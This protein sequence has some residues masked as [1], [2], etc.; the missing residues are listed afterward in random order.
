MALPF[1]AT[2]RDMIESML[3]YTDAAPIESQQRRVRL[4]ILNAYRE[5]PQTHEWRY[6]KKH[7]RIQLDAPYST[8]TVT[9]VASTGNVTLSGGTWPTWARQGHL[10]FTGAITGSSIIYKVAERL[11]ATLIRLEPDFSPA[12]SI[13]IGVAYKI[14]RS[15]YLLPGDILRLEDPQEESHWRGRGYVTPGEWMLLERRIGGTQLPFVWTIMGSNDAYGQ[16]QL[17][18]H[19]YPATAQTLDIPYCR[20][21]RPLKLDGYSRYSSMTGST[22][23]AIS[24]NDV[25]LRVAVD[26]DVIGAVFRISTSGASVEPEGEHSVNAYLWQTTIY[27]RPTP[28]TLKLYDVFPTTYRAGI[29]FTISDPVDVAPYMYGALM[30]MAEY[31]LLL[32]TEPSRANAFRTAKIMALKE[33]MERDHIV[34]A[35]EAALI[36]GASLAPTTGS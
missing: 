19:G 13:A 7:G 33:A 10:V 30:K 6:F 20:S 26:S 14:Y 11:S 27:D 2:M 12:D 24:G 31:E 4:A 23:T 25:T 1:L 16:M 3:D 9:Y 36:P 35:P 21:A 34:P 8:G 29:K 18:V 17:A 32:R 28:T 22:V 15:T 5:L